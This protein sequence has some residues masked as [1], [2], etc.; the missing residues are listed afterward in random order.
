MCLFVALVAA[1]VR[2]GVVVGESMAP[3]FHSGQL[4]LSSSVRVPEALRA[5]DVVLVSV[6]EQVY[7]KRIYATERET[8]WG[9][10]SPGMR[11][12]FDRVIA[13]PDVPTLRRLTA[14]HPALGEV[15]QIQV[16]QGH[17]YVLGDSENNSHDS[18][19]FGPVPRES[20]RSRVMVKD[21]GRLW[22]GERN[23]TQIAVATAHS[24]H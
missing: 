1:P 5:G 3:E 8:V 9:L 12:G 4:F 19:H 10:R 13:P 11:D 21:I 15:A 23:G 2:P 7:L 14:R 16:P 6:D 22:R 17:V 18:R 20:V 24:P